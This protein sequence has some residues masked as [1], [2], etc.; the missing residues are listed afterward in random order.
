MR[1]LGEDTN[2][3]KRFIPSQTPEKESTHDKGREI[4]QKE[5]AGNCPN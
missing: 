5:I 4:L 2:F 1:D 3:P